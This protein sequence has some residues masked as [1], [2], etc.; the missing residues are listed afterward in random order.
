M[1]SLKDM[2]ETRS[3][4]SSICV[5]LFIA[6]SLPPELT[7]PTSM[8]VTVGETAEMTIEGSDGNG[9]VISFLSRETPDGATFQTFS[10]HA[11]FS[12]T[13]TSRDATRLR[14]VFFTTFYSN[15]DYK[16]L[17]IIIHIIV[18]LYIKFN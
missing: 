7:G 8:N 12:W 2:H 6:A 13:P 14:F 5:P 10:A 9:D 1:N 17:Y 11:T 4:V 15:F 18:M 3:S 16:I